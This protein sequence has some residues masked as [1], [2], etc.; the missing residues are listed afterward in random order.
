MILQI[1]CDNALESE[2]I[3]TEMNIRRESE[4]GVDY[5][6]EDILPSE[7]GLRRVQ[8]RYAN[9]L[10]CED[11][12]ATKFVSASNAVNQPGSSISYCKLL[13]CDLH[14]TVSDTARVSYGSSP[15][16]EYQQ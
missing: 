9:T 8:P 11:K 4:V 16:P 6:G 2:E 12:E 7:V 10:A 15:C 1:L 14:H 5:D 13:A 3:V